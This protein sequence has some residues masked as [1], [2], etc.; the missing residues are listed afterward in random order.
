[1][2]K[3]WIE[4]NIYAVVK[5]QLLGDSVRGGIIISEVNIRKDFQ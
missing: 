1:M 4:T 3:F 5:H 2:I